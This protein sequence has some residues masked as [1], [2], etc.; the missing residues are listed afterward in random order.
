MTNV[1]FRFFCSEFGG[2]IGE[3]VEQKV[4]QSGNRKIASY[5]GDVVRAVHGCRLLRLPE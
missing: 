5:L 3:A 2:N 4:M 1:F